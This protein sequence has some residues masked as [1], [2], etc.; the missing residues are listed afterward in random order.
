MAL[1]DIPL[2][3]NID[4]EEDLRFAIA[5]YFVELG[6]DL[7]ELSF[8]DYFSIQLGH[9]TL[10]IDRDM[11][12]QQNRVRVSG[13]SDL[14]LTRNGKSIAV[15][16]TKAPNH[17]LTDQ[18]A[19]QALSYARLL[20][21]MA[22]YAIVT[23]GRDT[24]VFDTFATTL[25]PLENPTDSLWSN[26]GQRIPSVSDD[27]K[28]EAAQT[29]IGINP[30]TLRTFC[31]K[32][33]T[34]A[35][36]DLKGTPNE[37][38]IYIP[39]VYLPRVEIVQAFDDWLSTNM[40]IFAVVGDSGHGKTN[41]MCASSEKLS[42]NGF[43]LF[44]SAA[45]LREGLLEAICDDFEWEFHRERSAAYVIRRFDSIAQAHNQRFIIFVDGLDEF[46]GSFESFKA[47]LLDFSS[48][49]R[50][51][52]IRL[53]IS[54]KSFDWGKLVIDRGQTY[55]RL[56]K[57][58]YPARPTVH[59]PQSIAQPD[60]KGVGVWLYEF[61]D[62]ELDT[63]FFQYQQTFSLNGDLKG[64]TKKECQVPLI[65]RLVADVYG[66]RN[67]SVPAEISSRELFDLYW[68]RRL[69]EIH[70]RSAAEQLLAELAKLAIESGNPQIEKNG[71]FNHLPLTNAVN[72]AYQDLLRLGIIRAIFDRN[73]Y[74]WLVFGF[75]KMRSYI[76]TLKVQKWPLQTTEDTARAINNLLNA[77]LGLETI[78]F[79]FTVINRGTTNLLTEIA[80]Q[81]LSHFRELMDI[82]ELKKSLFSVSYDDK[83]EPISRL[84]QY[85][86][87]YSEITRHLFPALCEKLEP[88]STG[89]VGLLISGSSYSLRTLTQAYPQ[90]I[91]EIPEEIASALFHQNAPPQLLAD[92]QPGRIFR[93]GMIDKDIMEKLP[94]KTAWDQIVSQISGLFV[95]RFLD[96]ASS[97]ELLQERIWEILLHEPSIF[98]QGVPNTG[99]F[100]QELGF[101]D[102]QDILK[103]SIDEL[104]ANIQNL[105]DKYK[106]LTTKSHDPGIMRW[107]EIH[108]LQLIRLFYSL[109]SLG[110][111]QTYLEPPLFTLD[112]IY[113]YHQAN[114]LT[115][116][117][118]IM[119]DILPKILSSY[120]TLVLRNFPQLV[121][122]LELIKFLDANMLVEITLPSYNSHRND[123]IRLAYVVLPSCNLPRKHFVYVCDEK[124]SVAN[125]QITRRNIG[126]W[127][128]TTSGANGEK[129]G[130]ADVSLQIGNLHIE[131]SNALLCFT[132]FPSHYPILDQVY[133]LLGYE[134][135]DL[136]GGEYADWHRVESGNVDHEFL[137]QW[138]LRH[139]MKL[140]LENSH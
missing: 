97:P 98:I 68:D 80:L 82:L 120:Q 111:L 22:P 50:E 105:L 12:P 136:L 66:G 99:R 6:F 106:D 76:Y 62:E 19:L 16:E 29:L 41:F 134:I 139:L 35:L 126:S 113:R 32:Q 104:I 140:R 116:S 45:R 14:L 73:H 2:E 70:E 51:Q 23:N 59:Q 43:V 88:N 46:P 92:L 20:L 133:Q 79:Y 42:D 57:S 8:E 112:D 26:N 15:V 69:S 39:D 101:K 38:K 138:I 7:N 34:F 137:D 72:E 129:F 78:E 91:V 102:I 130:R 21:E 90:S 3:F 74:E 87:C 86:S 107:Y 9:N 10:V 30:Q 56:A 124:D 40:L 109:R 61:T 108:I 17:S 36:E 75:E 1:R 54:C 63:V 115:L 96:E 125:I 18:D 52:S 31:Q 33:I 123:F 135:H 27:F 77:P 28:Y 131:E 67:A 117:V 89:N 24:Q 11:E 60:P 110:S 122:Y 13:R 114:D 83:Q 49:L 4:S 55:N 47:E 44:Y 118:P 127:I 81:N 25:T 103:A 100:W 94:Q 65:L 119:E 95:N 128:T 71:L 37:A 64:T 93:I 85:V 121:G 84:E 48:R 58:T 132:K 53:C 5:R